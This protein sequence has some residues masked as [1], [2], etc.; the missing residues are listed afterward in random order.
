VKTDCRW[1][2]DLLDALAS[3]R[4]PDRADAALREHVTTCESCADL[5]DVVKAFAAEQEA[6]WAES[7]VL[8]PASLVWL[9]AQARARAEAA[10]EAARPIA[11]MQALGFAGAAGLISLFIGSV[12]WWVWSRT[13][14]LAALPMAHPESLDMMGLAIRGVLLAIGL[15]LV[16]APVA[17]YLAAADD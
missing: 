12:A 3:G 2:A 7:S 8:P 6:A 15:W 16:L 11:V 13:D 5:A 14:W 4:W 1:E 10:R 9:R 17:V